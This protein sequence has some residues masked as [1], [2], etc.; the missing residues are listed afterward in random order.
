LS[1]PKPE[2]TACRSNLS[3]SGKTTESIDLK[4][5]ANSVSE[6]FIL[7]DPDR[8][9]RYI[10]SAA[11]QLLGMTDQSVI[12]K[13]L[14]DLIPDIHQLGMDEYVTNPSISVSV[15][16]VLRIAINGRLCHLEFR[17]SRSEYGPVLMLRDVGEIKSSEAESAELQATLMVSQEL[18]R[19]KNDESNASLEQLEQLQRRILQVDQLKSEFLDTTSHELRAPLNSVIGSLQ[20]VQEGLCDD[21]DE[22][23]DCVGNGRDPGMQEAGH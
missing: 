21:E 14:V 19:H 23:L 5:L 15:P 1:Q 2:P 3:P 6:G 13:K 11:G 8:K 9:V 12:Q 17:L 18:L 16:R 22:I 7:L 20:L 4:S 10:N